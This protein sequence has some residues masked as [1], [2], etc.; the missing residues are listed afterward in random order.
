M[1]TR[2]WLFGFSAA[3]VVAA[4]A[5]TVSRVDVAQVDPAAVAAQVRAAGPLGPM[6]LLVLLV[7]Q[8]VVAPL[9][10]EPLMMAAG[11]V[12]GAPGGFL[13]AWLGV[14]AGAV[15]CFGLARWFGRDFAA[16]FVSP[17]R[18]AVLHG[19]DEGSARTATFLAVLS[20]RLFAFTA[21]DVVSYGCGLVRFSFR[22]FLLAT[23]IGAV[24]KVFVFTYFGANAALRPGWLD[25]SIA[26]GS[27]GVLLVVPWVVRARRRARIAAQ[28]VQLG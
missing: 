20:L 14:V 12:Y 19:F 4:A 23:V 15:L 17:Q 25:W 28:G 5:W 11:F 24:P 18:L 3:V 16:R 13:I 7:L 1:S 10:S 27:L 8:C 21:F 9:P 6:V 22:W 26:A 2:R